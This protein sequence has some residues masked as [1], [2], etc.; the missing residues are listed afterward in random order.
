TATEIINELN[1]ITVAVPDRLCVASNK[2]CNLV[3]KHIVVTINDRYA[4]NEPAFNNFLDTFSDS[5]KEIRFM[6]VIDSEKAAD[7]A[8]SYL[9]VLQEKY[10]KRVPSSYSVFKGTNVFNEIRSNVQVNSD[11]A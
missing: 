10:G 5:I 6:S 8:E 9:K 11:T 3:P 4:L 2:L 1:T 7:E